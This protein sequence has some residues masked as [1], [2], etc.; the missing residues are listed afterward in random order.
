MT[1]YDEVWNELYGNAHEELIVRLKKKAQ[2]LLN[3]HVRKGNIARKPCEY[4]G[5][6]EAKTDGHHA[7]YDYPLDVIWL[8]RKHH[9]QLHSIQAKF[10]LAK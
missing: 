8:C 9:K 10:E 4:S 5:C 2:T 6:T 7:D 3:Y 1:T